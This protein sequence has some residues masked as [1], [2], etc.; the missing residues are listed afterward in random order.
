MRHTALAP[1]DR[2]A[3]LATLECP[4]PRAGRFDPTGIRK[5]SRTDSQGVGKVEIPLFATL[6][7]RIGLA[8][9]VVT[10]DAMHAQRGHSEPDGE[11]RS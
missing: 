7:D 5:V 1:A 3:R 11:C 2:T 6:L 4:A 8:G 9:A 10:A